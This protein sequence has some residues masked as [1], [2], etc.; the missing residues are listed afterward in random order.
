[1]KK[2]PVKDD[3]YA[4]GDSIIVIDKNSEYVDKIGVVAR[5]GSAGEDV[6]Y[7]HAQLQG[8]NTIMAFRTFQVQKEGI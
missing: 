6:T 1:M 7:I 3:T 8:V 4:P 2:A 5:L